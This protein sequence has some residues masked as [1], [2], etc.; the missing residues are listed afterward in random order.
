MFALLFL[1]SLGANASGNSELLKARDAQDRAALARIASER[2]MDAEKAPNDAAAQYTA[3]FAQSTPAEIAAELRDK[4]LARTAS[5]A[6]IPQAER[7]VSIDPK[8]SEY[9]RIY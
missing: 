7:A 9:H 4:D 1:L 6:G 3:A 2:S 8:P 5:D